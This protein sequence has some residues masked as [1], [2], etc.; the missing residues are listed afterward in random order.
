[1]EKRVEYAKSF[2]KES[3]KILLRNFKNK[4]DINNIELLEKSLKKVEA[5]IIGSIF[6]RYPIDS[7]YSERVG[8]IKKSSSYSWKIIPFN[9]KED[10][11]ESS[12]SII[13]DGENNSIKTT[14][15][16]FKE[17]FK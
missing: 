11:K 3:S 10:F 4:D 2:L 13:I 16:P 14:Y 1:M 8:E 17:I 15:L 5:H 7:I 9:F 6:N 12:L